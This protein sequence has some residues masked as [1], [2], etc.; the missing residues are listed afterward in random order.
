LRAAAERSTLNAAFSEWLLRYAGA[1][2]TSSD[3]FEEM[4]RLSHVKTTRPFS[5]DERNEL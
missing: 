2:M 1:G 4:K 5:R 3:Y